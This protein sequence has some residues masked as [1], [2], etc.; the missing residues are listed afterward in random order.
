MPFTFNFISDSEAIGQEAG[1]EKGGCVEWVEAMEVEYSDSHLA[2]LSSLTAVEHWT[3]PATGGL[4]NFVSSDAVSKRLQA[5]GYT[6]DLLP[7]LTS[8]TDLQP[9][10]YEGGLK[11]W[12]C[13]ED[14]AGWLAA[15]HIPLAGRRVL[16]LGCGAGLPGLLAFKQGATVWFSDYNED[17]LHHITIPNALLN[18]P[19]QPMETRFFAGDWADLENRFLA[20]EIQNE[21][22]KFD[23]ILSSETIYNVDNQTKLISIFRNY[24]KR[25]GVALV[26]AKSHYF[27][28]G[29][30]VQQFSERVERAG[31]GLQ[32]LW[33]TKEGLKR[34]ILS[35]K[36]PPSK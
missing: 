23:L 11:I 30:G 32:R 25:D 19:D 15:G 6:G 12:E 5:E 9:G 8:Q 17:V 34:E 13:S 21:S 1:K 28:V 31:L 35:V 36:L 2:S 7:A 33:R 10:V 3:D 16:E 26:A 4:V 22:H 14:L 24:L 20:K 29:G 27:G 18:V